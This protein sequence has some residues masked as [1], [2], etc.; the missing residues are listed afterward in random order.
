MVCSLSPMTAGIDHSIPHDPEQRLTEDEWM[1]VKMPSPVSAP[2]G[3]SAVWDFSPSEI[4]PGCPLPSLSPG[5]YSTHRRFLSCPH[6]HCAHMQTHTVNLRYACLTGSCWDSH[7]LRKPVL[8]YLQCTV[9]GWFPDCCCC[10]CTAAM[11]LIM[12]LPSVGM[13]TSGQ[14]WKWNWRTARALFSWKGAWR[15]IQMDYKWYSKLFFCLLPF[16]PG[17]WSLGGHAQCSSHSPPPF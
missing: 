15:D 4:H 17:C 3:A 16:L 2:C 10:F 12:P 8:S 11:M 14:P 13:P 5:P 6:Q 9:M 1:H 7:V